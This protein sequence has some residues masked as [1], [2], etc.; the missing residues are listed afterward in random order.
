MSCNLGYQEG[1]SGGGA[2]WDWSWRMGRIWIGERDSIPERVKTELLGCNELE[3]LGMLS[4]EFDQIVDY[5]EENSE[6]QDWEGILGLHW[7]GGIKC[8]L[9]KAGRGGFYGFWDRRFSAWVWVSYRP[10]CKSI[11][12]SLC[13]AFP[14]ARLNFLEHL[15]PSPQ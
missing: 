7:W 13:N 8:Q 2:F 12:C 10:W 15:S 14:W 9:R 3:W 11:L 1:F 5:L 4:T 6:R